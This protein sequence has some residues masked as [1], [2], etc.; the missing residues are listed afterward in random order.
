MNGK[1]DAKEAIVNS[2]NISSWTNGV[3]EVEGEAD[4]IEIVS[5]S[6]RIPTHLVWM[7]YSSLEHQFWGASQNKEARLQKKGCPLLHGFL[8]PFPDQ[9]YIYPASN[10]KDIASGVQTKE[11]GK[12]WRV[13]MTDDV[14]KELTEDY[15]PIA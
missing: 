11:S 13:E 6:D 7:H 9:F 3:N 2:Y 12:H 5:S 15:C 4:V 8:G 10:I 1:E 14:R